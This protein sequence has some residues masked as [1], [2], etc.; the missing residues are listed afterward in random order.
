[1][2]DREQKAVL[3]RAMEG[4]LDYLAVLSVDQEVQEAMIEHRWHNRANWEDKTWEAWETWGWFRNWAR[5]VGRFLVVDALQELTENPLD[6][7]I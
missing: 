5:T 7:V 1:M 6:P 3:K 2:L 4:F